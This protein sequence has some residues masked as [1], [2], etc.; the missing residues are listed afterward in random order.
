MVRLRLAF[1]MME[2]LRCGVRRQAR[3][4]CSDCG[5]AAAATEVDPHVQ[6]RQRLASRAIEA[7]WEAEA[8]DIDALTVLDPPLLFD[9]VAQTMAAASLARYCPV[10]GGAKWK[11]SPKT[12]PSP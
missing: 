7:R 12:P 8:L 5:K 11:C 4:P 10:S 9:V 2:C 1:N 3:F 6:A